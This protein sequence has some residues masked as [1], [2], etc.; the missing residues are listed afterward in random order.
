MCKDEHIQL[1]PI[2]VIATKGPYQFSHH[3]QIE[4]YFGLSVYATALLCITLSIA[5]H[6]KP[7]AVNEQLQLLQFVFHA[8][9]MQ[10]VKLH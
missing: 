9:H 10:A 1:R 2:A 6:F 7:L 3:M 8:Y 4:E 5:A